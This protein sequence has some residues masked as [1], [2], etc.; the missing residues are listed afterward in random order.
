MKKSSKEIYEYSKMPKAEIKETLGE[1]GKEK[2]KFNDF[3]NGKI[4]VN[5]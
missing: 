3:I 5:L 2:R 4:I 1:Y